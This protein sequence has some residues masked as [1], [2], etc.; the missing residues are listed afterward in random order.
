MA[1]V[2]YD[3][4]KGCLGSNTQPTGPGWA[5]ESVRRRHLS[6][7]RT[8]K[9][10][11]PNLSFVFSNSQEFLLSFKMYTYTTLIT[12]AILAELFRRC[13][14]ILLTAFTG[15]LSKVPGPLINK[16]TVFPWLYQVV[17]GNQ[18]NI[19]P[20]LFKK[21]GPVVRISEAFPCSTYSWADKSST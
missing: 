15:P 17:I 3:G 12:Y 4:V 19:G 14:L 5:S 21:Y 1:R 18:L 8:L 7:I 13:C 11:Q 2:I 9:L 20:P 16:L 10:S 6:E